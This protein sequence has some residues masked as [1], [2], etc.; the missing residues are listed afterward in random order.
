MTPDSQL[1]QFERVFA[2]LDSPI[3]VFSK[4]GMGVIGGKIQSPA[5]LQRWVR[6]AGRPEDF[7]VC[8]NP[9]AEGSFIKPRISDITAFNYW[10]IDL[11]PISV[12]P[13]T[14]ACLLVL[15]K[16]L[17]AMFGFLPY[18]YWLDSG[19]GRQ[20]WVP[21]VGPTPA[22]VGQQCV[23]GCTAEL[24]RR[25]GTDLAEAGFRVDEAC[26][27]ISHLARLP[28]TVNTKTGQ[29][30]YLAAGQ[31][32]EEWL[33]AADMERFAAPAP[34]PAPAVVPW[35]D[36][37]KLTTGQLLG[38][39]NALTPFNRAFCQQGTDTVVESRHRRATAVARQLRDLG[40]SPSLAMSW[41]LDGA[42]WS[43]PPLDT[44]FIHRLHKETFKQ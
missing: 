25:A 19:R 11:D 20:A 32:G 24:I 9:S 3:H 10:L 36:S 40:C 28:G 30:A 26:A 23:K 1:Q 38:W 39:W 4:S 41:L 2:L 43:K 5:A 33:A 35:D 22:A 13:S 14:A 44:A 29:F 21:V 17:A 27:E 42:R 8:L 31:G 37:V 15:Q 16:H 34:P 18:F 7:Y 6:A 12:Q